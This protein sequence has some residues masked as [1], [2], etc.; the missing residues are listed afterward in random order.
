MNTAVG[1]GGLMPTERQ[2]LAST[3]YPTTTA[4][5]QHHPYLD[6]ATASC[7]GG[8]N[9]YPLMCSSSSPVI[10]IFAIHSIVLEGDELESNNHHET[11]TRPSS[12]QRGIMVTDEEESSS[13][14]S[15]TSSGTDYFSGAALIEEALGVRAPSLQIR[16]HRKNTRSRVKFSQVRVQEHGLVVADDESCCGELHVQLDWA[17]AAEKNYSVEDYEVQKRV[18]K[19]S[20]SSSSSSSPLARRLTR[21]ERR[22]RLYQVH[23]GESTNGIT[24]AGFA[25][26]SFPSDRRQWRRDFLLERLDGGGAADSFTENQ[27]ARFIASSRTTTFS[28]LSCSGHLPEA[29]DPPPKNAAAAAQRPWQELSFA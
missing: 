9:S 2:Q 5:Y 24:G 14:S 18:K 12:W 23:G 10:D 29:Q 3:I 22:Q 25:S 20:S 21:S 17:H 27:R 4:S 11:T 13:S 8:P 15:S 28:K 19:S 16:R 6:F 7:I 1:G 26:S